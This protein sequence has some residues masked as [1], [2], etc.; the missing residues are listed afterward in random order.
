MIR[1][2]SNQDSQRLAPD[3]TP[4][5]DIIFIL[6]VFLLLT[7][8]IKLKT[9]DIEIPQTTEHKVLV[10][11]EQKNIAINLMAHSP[12]WALD[13]KPYQDFD[14]FRQSLIAMVKAAPDKAVIIAAD[15]NAKVEDM[16]ALLAFLQSQQ[17]RTTNLV[18]EE[19]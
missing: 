16:L 13:G 3:L 11:T 4:L 5:L 8:N 10:S 19:K 2:Q 17:I 12:L 7:A 6:M 1:L 15:K 9:L 18:M 14:N